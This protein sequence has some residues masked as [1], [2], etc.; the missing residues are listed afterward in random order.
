MS[1]INSVEAVSYY[2]NALVP[3]LKRKNAEMSI[4]ISELES[5]ILL[6]Q[7]KISILEEK[8]KGLEKK[9]SVMLVDS[10]NTVTIEEKNP[11]QKNRKIK[12]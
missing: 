6:Q 10:N 4:V 5:N 8:C 12:E 3:I 7:K 1:N 2:S 9:I 11:R